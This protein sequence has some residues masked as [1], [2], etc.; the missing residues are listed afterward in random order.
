MSAALLEYDSDILSVPTT[1]RSARPRVET[2]SYVDLRL[3]VASVTPAILPLFSF[4]VGG[5][6]KHLVH[7][8][9]LRVSFE[10]GK[11]FVENDSL[12][13]FGHGTTL[14]E[15]VDSFSRDLGY[16][17]RYYRELSR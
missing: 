3:S 8:L 17:W 14:Y 7:P 5:D 6:L 10:D 11:Y 2:Y 9:L 1:L 4:I 12:R 13:I 16:F 15:A